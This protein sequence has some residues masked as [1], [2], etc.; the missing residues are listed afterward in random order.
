[1]LFVLLL[2]AAS[3]LPPVRSSAFT[4]PAISGFF[5]LPV[6]AALMV[7]P[8]LDV[9]RLR[10]RSSLDLLAL[11]VLLVPLGLEKPPRQWPV[12]LV[13]PILAYLGVRMLLVARLPGTG[14]RESSGPLTLHLPREW[15][16][17]GIAVLVFVHFNWALGSN[18]SSDIAEGSVKGALALIHGHPLYGAQHGLAGLDPHTDTYG[19]VNYEAYVPFAAVFRGLTASHLATLLFDLLT[20]LLLLRLGRR[21]RS[22]TLGMTLAFCWLAF[23]FTLYEDALGF[24]DAV[25]AA[26]LVA[27]LLTAEQ[28]L[29]RGVAAALAVWTKLS[30]VALL[31]LLASEPGKG[32]R[33]PSSA[34]LF[35]L[36]FVASTVLV[37][38]PAL[39]HSSPAIFVTRTF[40]FQSNRAPADSLWSSLQLTY[41]AKAPWIGVASRLAHAILAVLVGTLAVVSPRLPRRQDVVGLAAACAAILI[42]LEVCLSYYAYSYILWFAPLVLV[43]CMGDAVPRTHHWPRRSH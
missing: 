8:V 36:A 25:V 38:I 5:V 41:A 12:M 26:S 2:V 3:F 23:P 33:R 13:Y 31:P 39:L 19:P 42:G 24:N 22:S 37:F 6:F 1:V 9:R 16:L 27:V 32:R 40:G 11:V 4:F 10:H 7:L 28:P 29:R 35:L 20:A 30:P 15:L 34:A 43:A 17:A 18:V 21:V 14:V